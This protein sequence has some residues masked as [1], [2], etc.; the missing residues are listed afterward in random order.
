R[1]DTDADSKATLEP[2]YVEDIQD[3]NPN[4]GFPYDGFDANDSHNE[5]IYNDDES[6]SFYYKPKVGNTT[7]DKIGKEFLYLAPSPYYMPRP[8][9]EGSSSNPPNC[10]K[11]EWDEVHVVKPGILK[12]ELFKDP[13]VCKAIIDLV[14][15]PAQL[16]KAE[17]A[18]H[19]LG[20]ANHSQ[21]K[22]YIKYKAKRDSLVLEKEKI[23]NELLKIHAASKQD[24]KSFAK[25]S[26]TIK[27]WFRS[28]VSSIGVGQT[29]TMS[30]GPDQDHNNTWCQNGQT[31]T[32][33]T[34]GD[35]GYLR[36]DVANLAR[37]ETDKCSGE[38]D[39]LKDTSG[40]ES[41]EELWRNWYVER[42]TRSGVI[43]LV[44]TQQYHETVLISEGVNLQTRKP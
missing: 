26:W 10:M 14:P 31:M 41:P 40:P 38:A 23:E 27:G 29:S 20:K 25:D 5:A 16:L 35:K 42:Q 30:E 33:I 32:T 28:G 7:C 11:V 6:A 13:K 1:D 21:C 2:V 18:N 3:V 12:K 39:M 15:T 4:K 34:R 19:A 36:M 22:K 17:E 37:A 24:K 44:L 8:Y 9:D 43:S